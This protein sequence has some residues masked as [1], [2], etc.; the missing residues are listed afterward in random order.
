MFIIQSVI[1]GMEKPNEGKKRKKEKTK[2]NGM[3]WNI[4]ACIPKTRLTE[5]AIDNSNDKKNKNRNDRN[6]DY[7]IGSHPATFMSICVTFMK[8]RFCMG[9]NTY[10]PSPSAFSPTYQHSLHSLICQTWYAR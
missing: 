7:P 5:L 4:N 3:I 6:S 8:E 9:V 2:S 1:R 10:G